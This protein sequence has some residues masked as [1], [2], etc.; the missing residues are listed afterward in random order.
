[1]IQHFH[2][3]DFPEKLEK[4]EQDTLSKTIQLIVLHVFINKHEI[5]IL[6]PL[7]NF[8]YYISSFS[9]K[10]ILKL[11]YILVTHYF[12]P[13]CLHEMFSFKINN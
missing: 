11:N 5:N 13:V 6:I 10:L 9:F 3:S 8:L 1:M 4:P 7:K 2:N 12:L